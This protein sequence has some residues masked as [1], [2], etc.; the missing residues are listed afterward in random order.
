[1]RNRQSGFTL[2]ELMIVIVI[3]G[4]I[5]GIAYPTYNDQIRKGRRADAMADLQDL[6]LQQERHRTNNPT[7]GATA[8]LTIPASDFYN[9]SVTANTATTFT[10]QAVATGDQTNDTGCTTLT[11][12]QDGARTPAACW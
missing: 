10:L 1:M 2:I 5:A 8:D 4:I 7:Y 9:Y 11:I 12:N 6:A 3:L